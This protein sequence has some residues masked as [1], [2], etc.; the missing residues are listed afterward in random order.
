M[1]LSAHIAGSD[2][3]LDV[4][5]LIG[6]P[7]PCILCSRPGR[8]CGAFEPFEPWLYT[9]AP[10]RAESRRAIFYALC[11]ECA[12]ARNDPSRSILQRVESEILRCHRR[13]EL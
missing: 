6:R 8:V 1:A 11:R 9:A 5:S 2:V 3:S 10:P 12:Q 13:G 7:A 4:K